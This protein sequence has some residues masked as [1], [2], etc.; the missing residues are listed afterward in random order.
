MG[1][2]ETNRNLNDMNKITTEYVRT[3]IE[4]F[5]YKLLSTCTKSKEKILVECDKRHKYFVT[6][7]N[8]KYGQRCPRCYSEN[9]VSS[10]RLT[11]KYLLTTIKTIGQKYYL[12]SK[13]YKNNTTKL[14][15]LCPEK[16]IFYMSWASFKRGQRCPVCANNSRSKKQKTITLEYVQQ[17]VKLF[18]Y[19]CFSNRYILSTKHLHLRCDKGHEIYISWSNFRKGHRCRYCSLINRT[20]YKNDIERESYHNY[21]E[22]IDKLTNENFCKYYYSINPKELK[23]A[24]KHYHIDHIYSIMNGFKNNIPAKVIANPTN[25]QMLW[26]KDNISKK[27]N[28][29]IT[30]DELYLKYYKYLKELILN[31]ESC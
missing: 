29:D 7:N 18:R 11:L 27:D 19:E 6:W 23:R 14:K 2:G 4:K 24:Y 5:G 28:S 17:Y 30:I 3:E 1:V 8:F 26:Y 16:H 10:R 9:R 31:D 12:L 15:F 25:L 13:E 21:K 20:K 22:Y